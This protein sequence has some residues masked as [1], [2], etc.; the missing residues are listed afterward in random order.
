MAYEINGESIECDEEG[1]LLEAN[2]AD[3]V[4]TASLP[5]PRASRSPRTTGL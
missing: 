1:Y 5:R 3:E 4:P 2:Y